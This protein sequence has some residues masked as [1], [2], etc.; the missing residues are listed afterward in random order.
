M[1]SSEL[2][3]FAD[4]TVRT[5]RHYHQVGVLPEAERDGS[6]Y[7]DYGIHDLVRLLRIKRLAALGIP[8]ERMP[9]ILDA[10]GTPATDTTVL[11]DTLERDLDAEI[12]R[13]NSQKTL[14]RL[15]RAS[16]SAPDLP[17][18]LARFSASFAESAASSPL[19]RA[20]REHAILLAHLVGEAGMAALT[21]IYERMADPEVQR[22]SLELTREFDRLPADATEA[23]TRALADRF[24]RSFA[25][26]VTELGPA[27]IELG[28]DDSLASALLDDYNAG[29]FSV[30]QQR[31]FALILKGLEALGRQPD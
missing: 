18:A 16:D 25:P 12:A 10:D 4:V 27:V 2:A 3:A 14:I 21:S 19:G 17:P 1:K 29:S 8:L 6:G 13:L 11:L 9:A 31:V 23:T 26:L 7:R 15:I 28:V 5:L 30:S 20:D 22:L 24:I